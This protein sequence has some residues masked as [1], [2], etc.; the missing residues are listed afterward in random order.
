MR[1]IFK[2]TG[3]C[4]D[5]PERNGACRKTPFDPASQS[6][7]ERVHARVRTFNRADSDRPT[8]DILEGTFRTLSHT[9]HGLKLKASGIYLWIK[10][11][12]RKPH[13]EF[14]GSHGNPIVI[15]NSF[16]K[17]LLNAC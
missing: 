3:Q 7:I 10:F 15:F 11:V 6:L 9:R 12:L 4:E 14:Y 1:E 8:Y 2:G 5:T 16:Y 17:T 13:E